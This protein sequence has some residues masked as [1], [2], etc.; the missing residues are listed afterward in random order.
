MKIYIDFDG[1]LTTLEDLYK[2]YLIVLRKYH[3]YGYKDEFTSLHGGLDNMIKHLNEKYHLHITRQEYEKHFQPIQLRPFQFSYPMILFSNR[4]KDI[5]QQYFPDMEVIQARKPYTEGYEYMKGQILIDDSPDGMLFAKQMPMKSIYV[6]SMYPIKHVCEVTLEELHDFLEDIHQVTFRDTF[7]DITEE[8]GIHVIREN[9]HK[10]IAY[11]EIQQTDKVM[12]ITG[13]T[14]Y[15]GKFLLG[16]RDKVSTER[17]KWEFIPSGSLETMY[18]E[19][20]IKRE[21]KEETGCTGTIK[22][23]GIFETQNTIEYCY[24]I[25]L[26]HNDIVLSEEHSEYKWV[27]KYEVLKQPNMISYLRVCFWYYFND[28]EVQYEDRKN[29]IFRE[30]KKEDLR[31]LYQLRYQSNEYM[32]HKK[33]TI[34]EYEKKLKDMEIKIVIEYNHKII[35]FY[36][37]EKKQVGLILHE[38]YRNQGWG[39]Y[40]LKN[41]PYRG[42]ATIHKDNIVSQKLFQKYNYYP[43]QQ[44]NDFISYVPLQITEDEGRYIQEINQITRFITDMVYKKTLFPETLDKVRSMRTYMFQKIKHKIDKTS[45]MFVLGNVKPD[46][47]ICLDVAIVGN[48]PNMLRYQYGDEIN[49]TT[50]VIRFNYHHLEQKYTKHVGSKDNDIVCGN[51]TLSGRKPPNHPYIKHMNYKKYFTYKNK[52]LIFFYRNKV[53]YSHYKK[54]KKMY[55]KRNNKMYEMYISDKYCHYMLRSFGIQNPLLHYQCGTN[56]TL[57]LIDIGIQPKVYGMDTQYCQDNYYYYWDVQNK[58][59]H[60]M[61]KHHNYDYEL[62]LPLRLHKKKLIELKT[63]S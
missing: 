27:D 31:T 43:Y 39:S 35:G 18:V 30:Y 56:T 25:Q 36:K 15:N 59:C 1:T 28:Y 54:Y 3:Y 62:K 55:E 46:Y 26:D 11:E 21:L 12:C 6:K 8:R 13:I 53:Q 24:H 19:Q 14:E 2:T 61:S 63:K 48:S 17:Y 52:H 10:V 34:K 40:I 41:I 51:F 29:L 47:Y 23:L 58:K 60:Q 9:E 45:C 4:R 50:K 32:L 22:Y 7:P 5:V 57:L 44:K 33:I 20:E 38:K 16:K 37:I 49:R 42:I